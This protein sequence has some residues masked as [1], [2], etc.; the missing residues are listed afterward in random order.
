MLS[1]NLLPTQYASD[2][3]Q[4]PNISCVNS[5][6]DSPTVPPSSIPLFVNL[7][8]PIKAGSWPSNSSGL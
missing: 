5:G 1:A 8:R 7:G 2:P 6:P 4:T 3:S